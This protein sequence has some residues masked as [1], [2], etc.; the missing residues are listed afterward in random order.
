M[1]DLFS[2]L[3]GASQVFLE[4]KEWEVV[5]IDNNPLLEAT[6]TW[7]LMEVGALKK[8][9]ELGWFDGIWMSP[10][11]I[12][13]YKC[14]KP[15][16][17]DFFGQQPDMTLVNLCLKVVELLKPDWW[18]ME[19]T[20]SGAHYIR[21]IVG[22]EKQ[23]HGPFYLWGSFPRFAADVPEG[24]KAANDVWSSDPMR[25]NIKAKVP[26]AISKGLHDAVT[27]QT[28]LPI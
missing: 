3:H 25:S 15:F 23:I 17:P 24:I 7:D 14:R 2:G 27:H 10:P 20:K 11:C 19:N 9:L 12:E 5:C 8:I 16:Y 22:R 21:P 1:L 28:T 26:R 18:V 13:F 6:F 4:D